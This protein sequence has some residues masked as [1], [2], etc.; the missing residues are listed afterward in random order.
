M[1]AGHH[2]LANLTVIL[3]DN[4]QQA[5]AHSRDVLDLQ[6]VAPKLGTFGWAVSEV[7]GH[8][9]F[10][11]REAID[12][13]ACGRPR[14]IQAHTVAGHGVSFMEGQVAWHYLPMKPEDYRA[15]LEEVARSRQAGAQRR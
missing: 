7:D 10:Q 11:L 9:S 12:A 1:F 8:D 2:R 4:G 13:P 5:L 6:P 14:F 3:D 15:A